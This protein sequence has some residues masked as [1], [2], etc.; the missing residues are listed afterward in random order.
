MI[1]VAAQI[2]VNAVL[3]WIAAYL[4]PGI[5]FSGN[6]VGL[7]I[8]GLIFGLINWLIKPILVLVTLPLTLL[9]LG[10]F[11]LVLNALLLLLTSALS[12]D[13]A[14]AG[15]FPALLGSILISLL[16]TVLN[17]FVP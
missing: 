4:V 6:L 5:S 17:R 14:V 9:T 2:V 7:L 3:L 15:F 13:Y 12:P 16:S 1:T 11:A 10:L 8:L